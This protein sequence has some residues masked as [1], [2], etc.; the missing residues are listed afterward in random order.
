M[1]KFID[2]AIGVQVTHF[3]RRFSIRRKPHRVYILHL[4]K[5]S[6][7][8]LTIRMGKFCVYKIIILSSFTYDTDFALCW[9][10]HTQKA[11]IRMHEK[12]GSESGAGYGSV[13]S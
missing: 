8:T 5:A 6:A 3:L 10:P 12:S 13:L 7:R 11:F 4:L 9:V 2:F 1:R